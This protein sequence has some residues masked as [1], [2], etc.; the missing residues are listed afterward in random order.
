MEDHRMPGKPKRRASTARQ[1]RFMG[2]ELER[3]RDGKATATGMSEAQ[4]REFARKPAG[5]SGGSRS[6]GVKPRGRSR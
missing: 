4:L 5:K 6:G 3:K 2:A 1:Q